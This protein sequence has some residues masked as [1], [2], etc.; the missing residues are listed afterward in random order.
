L[1]DKTDI[2]RRLFAAYKV[3]DRSLLEGLLADNLRFTSPY[4]DGI[5]KTTYFERCWP[6]SLTIRENVI[7]RI[8]E[9]GDE[10]FVTY[11]CVAADGKEFRNTEFFVFAGDKVKSI[12][13]YFGAAYKDGV[14]VRQ[15]T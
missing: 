4:D 15:Q 3:K 1:S 9:Q 6:N 5:D 13:V 8:F 7:E 11:K 10:A 12:D 14:F 2:I